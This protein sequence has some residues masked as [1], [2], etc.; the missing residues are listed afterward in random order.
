MSTYSDAPKLS[1]TP[2]INFLVIYLKIKI[3]KN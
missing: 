3:L 2:L 1:I